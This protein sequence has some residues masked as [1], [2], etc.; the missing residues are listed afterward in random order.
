MRDEGVGAHA[1]AKTAG[2]TKGR[3]HALLPLLYL[4][5]EILRDALAG[6]LPLRITLKHLLQAGSLLDW[7]KQAAFLGVDDREGSQS[8]APAFDAA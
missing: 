3:V 2:V 7:S 4:S 8:L 6:D 1:L 5:P